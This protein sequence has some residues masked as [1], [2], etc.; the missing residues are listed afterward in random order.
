MFKF[1]FGA[2]RLGEDTRFP[3]KKGVFSYAKGSARRTRG[4][5]LW[6]SGLPRQGFA[7]LGE[8]LRLSEG[9]LRLGDPMTMLRHVFMTCL[10]LFRGPIFYYCGFLRGH[11]MT[12]LT[13]SLLD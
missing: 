8:P 13:V 9:M 1:Q 10:G 3:R 12:C 11:C 4:H 7:R 6:S 5:K 2:L